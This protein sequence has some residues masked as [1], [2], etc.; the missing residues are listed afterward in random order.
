M[1]NSSAGGQGAS[2]LGRQ[3]EQAIRLGVAEI[4]AYA[5]RDDQMGYVGYWVWPLLGFDWPLSGEVRR[6]LPADLASA[7]RLS[8]LMQTHSGQDWWRE[9]GH[10]VSLVFDLSTNSPAVRHLQ[11]YLRWKGLP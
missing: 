8:D 5:V 3:V 11:Y 7:R 9:H 4:R 6:R 10:P 2:L 1:R